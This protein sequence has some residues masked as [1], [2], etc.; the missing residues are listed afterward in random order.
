MK[1]AVVT[2]WAGNY[3]G[4]AELTLPVMREYCKFHNYE[5]R[6]IWLENGNE[7]H[8]K[9]HEYFTELFKSDIEAI[10]YL[11]IDCLITDIAKPI[12][13]FM[14]EEH[15]LFIT[16]DK[17]ELNGGSIIIKN[18]AWARAFNDL[19]LEQRKN[20]D[21]EQNVYVAF[22]PIQVISNKINVLPHPSI[23][24]YL[25][26][27]YP[28]YGKLTLEEGQWEEGCFVLHTPAAPMN[29]RIDAL[30]NAKIIR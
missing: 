8:F 15:D 20:F 11:D 26:E 17:T 21:N 30:K 12:T 13:D 22:H 25:Y 1:I 2:M 19:V 3:M 23:N 18:T 27:L 6:E 24:S 7:Y 16:E 14:D 10:W 28:E 5:F 4:I 9:K 29:V